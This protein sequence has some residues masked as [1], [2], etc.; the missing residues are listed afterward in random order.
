MSIQMYIYNVVGVD[1][2]SYLY[3]SKTMYTLPYDKDDIMPVRQQYDFI[4]A[5]K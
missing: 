5:V 3:F 2:I 1:N 4:N